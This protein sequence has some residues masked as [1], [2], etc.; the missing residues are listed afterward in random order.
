GMG[1][2]QHTT[3]VDNVHACANLAMLTAH[4]GHAMTGLN[5]LRGQNNVQGSCDMGALPEFFSGYQRVSDDKAREKFEK[6]W[7]VRL[8]PRPGLT[9]TEMLKA[10]LTKDLRALYIMGE[11]PVISDP[12]TTHTIEALKSL[13]FLAV[14]DIFMTETTALADVVLPAVTFAEKDGTF[15]NTERRVQKL[16]K[17]VEPIGESIPDWMIIS[18]LSK[19]MGYEMSYRAPHEI[20]E[21]AALLT[22]SYRGILHHRLDDNFGIQ[23]PCPD[24]VHPGTPYLHRKKFTR[25]MGT[26][27]PTSFIPPEE[28]PDREFPLILTTGRNY[29]QY[30]TGT[31]TRKTTTLEREDP[32]CA[33][34]IN[35]SDAKSLGIRH[36][37]KIKVSTRRGSIE[38]LANVTD[39]IIQGTIYVPFHFSEAAANML[40]NPV[41]DRNAKI[42]EFKVCAARV[43]RIYESKPCP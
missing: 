38:A 22:P 14:Q 17:A 6:A 19:R 29:F 20:M 9:L 2:T 3:G 1:S 30:H 28:Q 40:T 33:V 12:D 10:S 7:G 18:E 23:W 25:G 42:P 13:D 15:T 24:V 35:T 11:N 26:F 5:P 31:M 16:R 32:Q 37:E 36:R 34:E 27:I 39:K 8:S 4:V 43:E 41:S 21:E